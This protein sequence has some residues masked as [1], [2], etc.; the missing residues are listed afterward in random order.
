MKTVFALIPIA[1]LAGCHAAKEVMPDHPR[2]FAGVTMRDVTFHSAALGRDM[3]Y[4]VYLPDH[5]EAGAKLP[6]VV[7][8]HG[9]A[10][11]FWNWSDYSDVGQY[12]AKGMLLVMPEGDSYWVNVAEPPGDRYEDY[13]TGDLLSDVKMR[14]PAASGRENLAIVGVSMGGFAAVK[15]A[16]TRPDLFAFAGAISPAIDSPASGFNWRHVERSLRFRRDFGPEG[17]ARRKA[18][19]PF[20]L[21]KTADPGKTPYLYMT[22][23]EKE[24]LRPPNERFVEELKRH[25]FAYEFHTKPGGHDWNQWDAQLPGCMERLMARSLPTQN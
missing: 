1:L 25:G 18:L 8:L 3:P 21:V 12:A 13:L 6:V 2:S 9:G 4:R 7:L 5:A 19:D 22:V 14:F 23:G 16:L 20:V 11:H 10:G 24:G 17:S 15:L